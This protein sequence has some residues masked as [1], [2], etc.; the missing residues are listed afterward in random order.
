MAMKV[1]EV[2]RILNECYSTDCT[3]IACENEKQAYEMTFE[4]FGGYESWYRLYSFDEMMDNK[5]SHIKEIEGLEYKGTEPKI[6]SQTYYV[7]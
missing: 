7:E 2:K 5:Y 1:F 4:K 6:L 3:I